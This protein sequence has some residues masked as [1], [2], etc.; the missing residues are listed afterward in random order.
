MVDLNPKFELNGSR[1][2]CF[3]S[4]AS[5]VEKDMLDAVVVVLEVAPTVVVLMV[6]FEDIDFVVV[7]VAVAVDCVVGVIFSAVAIGVVTIIAVAAVVWQ[8]S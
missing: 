2:I 5:V 7:V 1:Q 8:S 6:L 3:T 4:V